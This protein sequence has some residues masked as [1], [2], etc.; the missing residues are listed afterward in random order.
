MT[1]MADFWLKL[2]YKRNE[3]AESAPCQCAA[4]VVALGA[5]EAEDCLR[6]AAGRS[7]EMAPGASTALTAL[8]SA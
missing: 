2:R 5:N 7:P 4:G 1:S 3:F 8:V 6:A